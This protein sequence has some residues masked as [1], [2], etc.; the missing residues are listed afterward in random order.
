MAMMTVMTRSDDGDDDA[1]DEISNDGKVYMLLIPSVH[2]MSNDDV[3]WMM[4][5]VMDDVMCDDTHVQASPS[6]QK[7][8]EAL[9]KFYRIWWNDDVTTIHFRKDLM[10]AYAALS[11]WFEE[12]GFNFGDSHCV[13]KALVV[14]LENVAPFVTEK[15]FTR[16]HQN[17]HHPHHDIITITVTNHHHHYSTSTIIIAPSPSLQHHRHNY[18]CEPKLSRSPELGNTLCERQRD[19]STKG[20]SMADFPHVSTSHYHSCFPGTLVPQHS[21]S[22]LMTSHDIT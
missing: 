16:Q 20:T 22:R 7:L 21:P 10:K 2:T 19:A 3:M 11:D 1:A 6:Q 13:T 12:N 8:I 14:L 17:H 18:H 15:V 5:C 9:L 4:W